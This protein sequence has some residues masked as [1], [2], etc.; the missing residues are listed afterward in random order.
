LAVK[1]DN[2]TGVLS[3]PEVVQTTRTI[4]D[5]RGIFKDE[6]A[7]AALDQS[8]IAYRVQAYEPVPEGQEGGIGCAT[9]FLEPGLVGDEYLM[10][11][12]HYHAGQDRPEL[13]VTICGEGA[14]VLMDRVRITSIEPMSP[15][16]VHHVPPGTAHRVAN[17]GSETLVFVSY[18]ASETGHDYQAIRELGFSARVRCIEGKPQLVEA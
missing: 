1:L 7:R 11:R 12:G 3:G 5:L 10:T 15:G 17:T 6:E 9:T 8:A 14:L 18:W 16:S 4:A 13:E 2:V